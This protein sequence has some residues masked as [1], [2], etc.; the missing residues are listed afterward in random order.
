MKY[1]CGFGKRSSKILLG[2]AYFG[3]TISES[4]SFDIMDKY[5]ELG[6]RHIDTA[7]LYAA[8]ES[9][10]VI[11]RWLESRR[12]D[13]IF[14]STKGAFPDPASP[15][16]PRVSEKEVRADLDKS[17]AIFGADRIDQYWLHRDDESVPVEVIIDFMNDLVKEGKI[18]QFGASNWNFSRI[19]SANRYAKE[20][21]LMGFAASQI[22]FSPAIVSPNG[23]ADR[24][25]VDMTPEAFDYY[26]EKN[27]PVAAYASQAKGFFSK[28][29]ELGEDGLSVKSKDRYLCGE[30]LRT[31]EVIKKLS[32]KYG[33]SIAAVVCG[34][35]A[36]L[37]R[38]D[39]FPIIGGSRVSQIE[40]SMS[41]AALTLSKDE[42]AEVFIGYRV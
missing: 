34:A 24:K 4:D 7:R 27:M 18:K 16:V 14:L 32:D 42:L 29:A 21:G 33:C 11:A 31:L 13:D 6:G 8:G 10:K 5:Y 35:L 9:E 23:T 15:D 39:V 37:S 30:N 1:S 20:N 36:S 38:V 26:A 25:L 17:L 3:D 40:D 28:M 12:Y 41:G 22:R 2:T 19:E